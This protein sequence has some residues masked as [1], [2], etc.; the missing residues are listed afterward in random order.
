MIKKINNLDRMAGRIVRRALRKSSIHWTSNV[1]EQY[2][3][4][5]ELFLLSQASFSQK[6]NV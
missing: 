5:K 6:K 4:V 3:N 2:N 1:F